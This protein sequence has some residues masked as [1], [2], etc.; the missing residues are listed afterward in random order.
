MM[1]ADSM[2]ASTQPVYMQALS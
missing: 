1:A 2:A